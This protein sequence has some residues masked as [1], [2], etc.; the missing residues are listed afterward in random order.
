MQAGP[1]I[2][3]VGSMGTPTTPHGGGM[4][5]YAAAAVA[6]PSYPPQ[7]AKQAW[8]VRLQTASG[9][10]SRAVSPGGIRRGDPVSNAWLS[11]H[12]LGTVAIRDTMYRILLDSFMRNATPFPGQ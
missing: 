8:L 5:G 7:P 2:Q 3:E 12:N 1:V 6:P 10:Q 9:M 4:P 11:E